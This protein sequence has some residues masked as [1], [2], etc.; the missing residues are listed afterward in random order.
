M[1]DTVNT[2]RSREKVVVVVEKEQPVS[3]NVLRQTDKGSQ[4][5]TG[6]T[7]ARQ[8]V[9][10]EPCS[11]DINVR[12]LLFVDL[13]KLFVSVFHGDIDLLRGMGEDQNG[14]PPHAEA[15]KIHISREQGAGV[16][17]CRVSCV[18][19]AA[20]PPANFLDCI[21]GIKLLIIKLF[22]A[23]ISTSGIYNQR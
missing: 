15:G 17:H 6:G 11:R 12:L 10:C 19:G 9:S 18:D 5:D 21:S 3:G 4:R 1:Q 7:H 20:L 8:P 13:S 14:V 23:L 22:L 2:L 16:L